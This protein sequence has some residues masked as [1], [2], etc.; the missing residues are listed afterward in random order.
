MSLAGFINNTALN[1]LSELENFRL[2]INNIQGPPPSKVPP[3][4]MV[5]NLGSNS[6]SGSISNLSFPVNLTILHFNSNSFTGDVPPLPIS[7]ERF[8]V[9]ATPVTGTVYLRSP[10]VFMVHNSE[11][12]RIFIDDPSRFSLSAGFNNPGYCDISGKMYILLK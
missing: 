7:I 1:L 6:L 2:Y 10:T 11:L 8:R 3:K 4:L 12:S 5:Y 9:D